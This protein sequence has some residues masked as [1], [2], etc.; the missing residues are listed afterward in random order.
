[1]TPA[2]LARAYIQSWLDKDID[3]F[4]GLLTPDVLVVESYGPVYKGLDECRT[5]FET[6]HS[7]P[8][9]GI[10]TSWRIARLYCDEENG[11]VFC[12]WDF[13]CNYEGKLGGFLGASLFVFDGE[14]I[15]EVHEYK[16][17]RDQYRPYES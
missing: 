8:A 5:W 4:L 3:R 1:M 10:V 9:N 17:E 2:A 16:T 12:D 6:W 13:E 14:K 7:P 15:A 11:A